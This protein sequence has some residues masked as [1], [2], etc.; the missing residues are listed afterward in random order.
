MTP[1]YAAAGSIA[2][3]LLAAGSASRFGG[4]KLLHPLPDGTPI[5]VAALRNLHQALPRVLVVVRAG[6]TVLAELFA[7]ERVPVLE[8]AESAQG[9]GHSLAAGVRV[10]GDAA[11]WVIALGDMPCVQSLTIAS[12]ASALAGGARV[13]VPVYRGKRGHPVGFGA[14]CRA[15]LLALRGDTGARAVL[16]RYAAQLQ[17]LEVDDPG[18]L[19][20]V[21]TSQDLQTLGEHNTERR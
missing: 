3:I 20:D 16:E 19:Q 12:V 13:V 10:E 5:G 2:G 17:R 7:R 21:D 14:S 9:M 11:G 15:E 1:A 6:D 8:C 4:G 18:V